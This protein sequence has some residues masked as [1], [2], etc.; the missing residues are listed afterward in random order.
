MYSIYKYAIDLQGDSI[1]EMLEQA[2]HFAYLY[3]ALS[4][5]ACQGNDERET[6]AIELLALL[7]RSR[8]LYT[9]PWDPP[10]P[11]ETR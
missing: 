7:Q 10:A 3:T 1:D 9:R 8:H 6:F 11:S 2:L 4:L 5:Y